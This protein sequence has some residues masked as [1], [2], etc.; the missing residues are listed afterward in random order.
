M[1]IKIFTIKSQFKHELKTILESKKSG[2]ST[3]MFIQL[4]CGISK[5]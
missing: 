5:F 4:N 3:S 2:A 1:K